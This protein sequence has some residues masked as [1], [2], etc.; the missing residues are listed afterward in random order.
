[1][2]MWE[3]QD[4]QFLHMTLILPPLQFLISQGPIVLILMRIKNR[5]GRVN[6]LNG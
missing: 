5:H 4:T 1:M 2:E 3:C 6:F